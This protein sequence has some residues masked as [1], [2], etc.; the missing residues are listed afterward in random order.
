[1]A[2]Y[3]YSDFEAFT[4]SNS[5]VTRLINIGNFISS[6]SL[7][8]VK[9]EFALACIGVIVN[10]FHL[11]VLSRKSLRANSINVIMIGIGACDLFNMSFVVY[12]NSMEMTHPDIECWPPSSYTAQLIDLWA[13]AIKDDLRRLT[14]W[15]GVLMAGIRFLIVK[16]SLNPKFKKLSDPKFSIIAMLI[17]FILSTCWSVFYWA[18]LTL[19]ETTPWKPAA[20]CTGFPPNYQETQYVL[21]VNTEFMNDIL[22]VIQVF[23]ITDGVLKIIPTIMFP[24]LTCL[25]IRE[26]KQAENSRKKISA[27]QKKE[28]SS[29]SDHTTNLVILMTVTFMTAE[30]PLGVFYVVQG[31]VTNIPGFVSIAGSLIEIFGIFV[32][33]NATTHCLICLTV[34]SQYRR[35]V[36][37]L[38][39]CGGCR[40]R[41]AST[42]V[43]TAKASVSSMTPVKQIV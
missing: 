42:I 18:R 38:F 20:H 25:L 43:V 33:L 39:L 14:P 9:Y 22:L 30:G 4:T 35:A 15:L 37:E 41:K 29:R 11:I 40:D 17:A 36:K 3:S 6:I 1:M 10:I 32:A 13:A 31:L 21:M 5:T 26:L 23:L 19:V 28:E 7:A 16:M 2:N 24:I 27:A 12:E 34:S 8:V